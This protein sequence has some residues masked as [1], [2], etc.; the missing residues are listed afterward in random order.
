[1]AKWPNHRERERCL[2]LAIWSF[3]N[4]A[5]CG[6]RRWHTPCV[7][8]L[9]SYGLQISASGVMTAMYRQDVFANNLANSQTV[10]FKADIPSSFARQDVRDEDNLPFLPS[11][12]LLERLGG[13]TLLNANRIDFTQG[14]L[15]TSD[16]DL[17]LAILG[18]G[19]LMVRSG[20]D[21]SG[22][23]L[24]MTRDGRLTRNSEGYLVQAA[25]G[26][27]VLDV[28]NRP[29]R[30]EPGTMVTVG[31]DGRLLEDGAEVATLA[32]IDV[33]DRT[34]IRKEGHSLF[35]PNADA[36]GGIK[37]ATGRIQQHAVEDASV[38]PIRTLLAMTSA[39]RQVE[40][41]ASMIQ[42]HDRLTERAIASLGR[43]A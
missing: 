14:Q 1:M 4:L 36:L 18:D 21:T 12:K 34:Q 5:I 19:F 32:F 43:P 15:K 42:A 16:S 38:D 39:A 17:D 10:G 41:N 31:S 29:I 9:V 26:M 20:A 28:Q 6:F 13:G 40:S 11:N 25:T 30:L 23:S 33:G 37:R 27:P 3:G 2:S 24:R 22:D 35:V 7:W 8:P